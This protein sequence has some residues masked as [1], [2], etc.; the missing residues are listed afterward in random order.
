MVI[1]QYVIVSV[2]FEGYGD[3]KVICCKSEPMNM[4]PFALSFCKEKLVFL[5][6]YIMCVCSLQCNCNVHCTE[7]SKGNIA[8][9]K[10]KDKTF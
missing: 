6:K 1:S 9:L 8:G 5:I 4:N 7:I 10:K 2:W 3:S